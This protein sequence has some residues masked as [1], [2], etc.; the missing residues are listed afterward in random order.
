MDDLI[1]AAVVVISFIP[2]I[3]IYLKLRNRML[4][5]DDDYKKICA[6]SFT[7]G[8]LASLFSLPFF[9]IL[10]LFGDA[11]GIVPEKWTLYQIYRAL[12]VLALSEEL[13]KRWALNKVLKN[14]QG[15]YSWADV[16]CF[17]TVIGAGFGLFEG[18]T[19]ALFAE[20]I[21]IFIRGPLAM[22]AGFGLIMGYFVGKAKFTGMKV[23]E[24]HAFVIPLI[25][26]FLYNY[27]MSPSLAEE[28]PGVVMITIF[29]G[30]LSF[31]LMITIFTF[32]KDIKKKENYSLRILGESEF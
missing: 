10:D 20:P 31:I 19:Y 26:Q 27:T 28:H 22:Q 13:L 21:Q 16:I 23:F 32:S 17:G 3:A 12:I 6:R 8:I 2:S 18:I 14:I 11:L 7:S 30:L 1:F 29:I 25:I 4:R 24:I 5:Q 15:R 9:Y